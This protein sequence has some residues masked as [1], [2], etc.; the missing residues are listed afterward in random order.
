MILAT[1]FAFGPLAGS[2]YSLLGCLLAAVITYAV[3]RILGRD[4][5]RRL[6]G[7]RLDRVNR[8]LADHSLVTMLTVRLLPIAPYTVVNIVAGAFHI[9][10][11]DFVFGTILGMAPGILAITVFERQLEE[12]IREP[13]AGSLS[14]LAAVV[15]A[16]AVTAVMVRRRLG[17][18]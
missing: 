12:A 2:A 9:R 8:R 6:A 17:D 13:G 3:G 10:F 4:K 1:A 7:S 11:R 14:L 15:A 16:I 5:V 18:N